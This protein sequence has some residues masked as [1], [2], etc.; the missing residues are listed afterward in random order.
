ME[1]GKHNQAPLNWSKL[2]RVYMVIFWW[3]PRRF[4]AGYLCPTNLAPV[5]S[6]I[7]CDILRT[8]EQIERPMI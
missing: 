3:Q 5:D 2:F 7:R 8:V 4:L 1:L 6:G